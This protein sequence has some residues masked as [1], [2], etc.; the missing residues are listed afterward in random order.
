MYVKVTSIDADAGR[1]SLSMKLC[2]QSDGRDLDPTHVE[3]R[4]DGE[5]WGEVGR[6]HLDPTHAEARRDGERWGEVGRSHLGPAHAE[7][8]SDAD[9]RYFRVN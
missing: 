7:A 5:R 8:H 1:Y 4:R 6:S 2:S 9:R 3:A